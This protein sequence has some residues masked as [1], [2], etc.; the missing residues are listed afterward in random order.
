MRIMTLIASA[1]LAMLLAACGD[2]AT[3]NGDAGVNPDSG[4]KICGEGT[5]YEQILNAPTTAQVI[6]KT[7]R[8]PPIGPGGLP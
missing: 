6:T 7:P 4:A 8:H 5:P 1:A 2:D 3:G